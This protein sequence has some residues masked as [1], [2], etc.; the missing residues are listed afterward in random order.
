MIWGI[1]REIY[2]NQN[3]TMFAVDDTAS[4]IGLCSNM[5]TTNADLLH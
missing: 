2:D 1:Y 3:R 4:K 5:I